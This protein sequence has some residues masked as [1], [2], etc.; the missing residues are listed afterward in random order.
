[1]AINIDDKLVKRAINFLEEE[2]TQ[3]EGAYDRQAVPG[4]SPGMESEFIPKNTQF[5]ERTEKRITQNSEG[6]YSSEDVVVKQKF[7]DES[8]VE[9]Q[10]QKFKQEAEDLQEIARAFDNEIIRLNG[11]INAKKQIIVDLSE[12]AIGRNCFPGLGRTDSTASFR[13][14]G[15]RFA[16][17]NQDIEKT[18]IYTK[19]AGPGFNPGA[20]NPFDPDTTVT[21]NSSYSGFGYENFQDN[22]IAFTKDSSGELVRVGFGSTTAGFTIFYSTIDGGGPEIGKGRFDIST[23]VTDHNNNG[24]GFADG[25]A[26]IW[27]Y[28][29][30][31][32]QSYSNN[33]INYNAVGVSSYTVVGNDTP[34]QSADRCVG[35]ANSINTLYSEIIDLRRERDSYRKNLNVLKKNKVE[36]ELSHWG[37][38]NTKNEVN[39]R[40]T[41][42]KSLIAA[43][44]QLDDSDDDGVQEAGLVLHFDASDNSSY[45]GS[46]TIWY[47][48]SNDDYDDNGTING[49][50]G[51]STSKFV[52]DPLDS[53]KNYFR[54]GG[55][56]GNRNSGG[57]YVDFDITDSFFGD[58]DTVTVEMLAQITI[59]STLTSFNQVDGGMMFGW[60]TYDVWVKSETDNSEFPALGFNINGIDGGV[61]VGL[62][63]Q[64]V[65]DLGLY[66][67]RL[68][69][70]RVE[71]VFPSQWAH[72]TFVM[73]KYN[74]TSGV[75]VKDQLLN[76]KIY[77]NGVSESIEE[78]RSGAT[79]SSANMIFGQAG[80]STGIGRIGG[81][82]RDD[83][84]SEYNLPMEVA[85]FRV[86]NK[87]LT[88]EEITANFEEV[89]GRFDL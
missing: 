80:I 7:Y 26:G 78:V 47:D 32:W 35:I 73:H 83:P 48:V 42:N 68:V 85:L 77:I 65:N 50:L 74:S 38:Q 13:Y 11:L 33:G 69:E 36:K 18:K 52:E 59:G 31:G 53:Q 41:K 8:I 55:G 3:L 17:I 57:E 82:R 25:N 39:V 70:E 21:L 66:N 16:N 56:S 49:L 54:F 1:M 4:V 87:E 40:K 34:E 6:L 79:Y 67:D 60:N 63:A 86:Y 10:E 20:E 64:R 89:R 44:K 37:Y 22:P 61:L 5:S 27:T 2:Q 62:T 81:W 43:I 76:N 45:F 23:S 9:E 58:P 19:M 51:V 14:N 29:G 88:Q 24:T 71:D 28:Q 72:Y 84:T 30:A 12:E 75:S 15:A 46:G